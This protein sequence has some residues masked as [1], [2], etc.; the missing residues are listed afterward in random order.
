MKIKKIPV[1]IF[2]IFLTLLAATV[3]KKEWISEKLSDLLENKNSI[4]IG[5]ISDIHYCSGQ[6]LDLQP[7]IREVDMEKTDFNLSLG[8]NINF[9][10]GNCS[11]TY[12]EDLSYIIENLKTE[13]PIHFVLGDHDINGN[14][15]FDYWKSKIKK[16]KEYYSF[17]EKDFHIIIMD[18]ILGGEEMSLPC[19]EVERCSVKE[20]EYLELKSLKKNYQQR[21]IF[22]TSKDWDEEKFE[23]ELKTI[24]SE[25]E[26]IKDEIQNTR[27]SGRRDIGRISQSQLDWIASDLSSSPMEKVIIFSDHPLF[28]FTSPRKEY[29][30]VNADKLRD[31]LKSSGKQ[32][33]CISGEAHLWHEEK[34]DG[35]QYYIVNKYSYPEKGFATFDWNEKG[36]TF[37]RHSY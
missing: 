23:N 35:I 10:V 26:Q 20:K 5:I 12:Q 7:F 4:K 2:F 6:K 17:E 9:R 27:S 8:D 11:E 21:K 30:V 24:E 22:L 14:S 19:E 36:Y 13:S 37:N 15:S 1:F 28:H 29:N 33:V 31:I 16:E 34:I 32:I 3:F 18:T 25:L